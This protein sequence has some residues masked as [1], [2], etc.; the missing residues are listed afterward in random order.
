MRKLLSIVGVVLLLGPVLPKDSL[1]EARWVSIGPWGGSILALAVDLQDSQ[2]LYAGT[3]GQGVFKS[4]NGG[5]TGQPS[6]QAWETH[7]F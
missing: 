5:E 7:P 6:R 4:K 3:Y 1:G 2:T